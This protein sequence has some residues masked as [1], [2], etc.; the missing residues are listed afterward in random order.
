MVAKGFFNP[1]EDARAVHDAD[2][3]PHE[4]HI[5]VGLTRVV[6]DQYNL[7]LDTHWEEGH[8]DGNM[9]PAL[10]RLSMSY[11]R[12]VSSSSGARSSLERDL[13]VPR[14]MPAPSEPL[15]RVGSEVA[16]PDVESRAQLTRS[17]FGRRSTNWE[18]SLGALDYNG[19]YTDDER[20]SSR[21]NKSTVSRAPSLASQPLEEIVEA[22]I[23][24]ARAELAAT[25]VPLH[26]LAYG[27]IMGTTRAKICSTV[28][29]AET[30]DLGVRMKII[31]EQPSHTGTQAG[32]TSTCSF[33]SEQ[34]RLL[35]AA[36]HVCANPNL[37]TGGEVT[38]SFEQHLLRKTP[39]GSAEHTVSGGA[40][41]D[42]L[43]PQD[44]RFVW[45]LEVCVG[46]LVQD[47]ANSATVAESE[48]LEEA[49]LCI[50]QRVVAL[51]PM[52]TLF[53]KGAGDLVE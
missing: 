42:L 21:S 3:E 19:I 14:L 12:Q 38:R 37:V 26:E 5:E 13:A 33:R 9:S 10:P 43:V 35:F 36:K 52:K 50:I 47:A 7:L 18:Q 34:T 15:W 17:G 24:A 25:L 16:V 29:D 11:S 6:S 8:R 4:K 32:T 28:L 30:L 2:R 41:S 46:L 49:I 53:Y 27:T 39:R 51:C 22:D 45:L 1:Y 44:I 20:T 48:H 23:L 31:S 40:T